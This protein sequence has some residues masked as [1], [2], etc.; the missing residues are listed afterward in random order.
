MSKKQTKIRMIH[1]D[2]LYDLEGSVSAVIEYLRDLQEKYETA[3]S[4]LYLC[5]VPSW[6][7]TNTIEFELRRLETDTEFENRLA[8]EQKAKKK[9]KKK[10][11]K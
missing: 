2:I 1:G 4:T 5:V 8:R 6:E 9:K 3:E 11:K 10:K 7:D